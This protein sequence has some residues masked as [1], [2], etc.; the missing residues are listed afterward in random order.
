M[1]YHVRKKKINREVL[2]QAEELMCGGVA[3]GYHKRGADVPGWAH[4]NLLAH[5]S[6]QDLAHIAAR[7]GLRHPSTWDSAV[8]GLAQDLIRLDLNGSALRELQVAALVPL[9]LELLSHRQREPAT[10]AQLITLVRGA[11]D[12]HPIER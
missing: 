2:A 9:E 5:G 4:V 8:G 11:L 3:A 12:Q 1:R 10:P 7:A 6:Y